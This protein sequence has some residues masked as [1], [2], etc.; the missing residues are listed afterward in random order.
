VVEPE[1]IE[2]ARVFTGNGNEER[3]WRRRTRTEKDQ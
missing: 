1:E 2:M 3:P